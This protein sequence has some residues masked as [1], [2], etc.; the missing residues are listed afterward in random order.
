MPLRE[1]III[2]VVMLGLSAFFSGAETALVSISNHRVRHMAQKGGRISKLLLRLKEDPQRMLTTILIGNNLVNIGAAAFATSIAIGI[3]G[4]TGVGIATGVMTLLILIFGEITPKSLATQFN[5]GYSKLAALPIW[6]LSVILYPFIK[7]FDWFFRIV[8]KIFGGKPEKQS[9]SED[10][11]KSMVSISE[12]EGEIKE[13]EK[14]MVNKIFEFDDINADEIMTPK[15]D[16]FLLD[17]KIKVKKALKEALL[18]P[19]SRIPVYEDN[20][21]NIV[22]IVHLRDLIEASSKKKNDTTV[23]KIMKKPYFVPETK[24]IDSLLKQFQKKKEHMAII[25]DEHGIITGLVT[26]ED[27]LE[28]IVGE[29]MDET[30]KRDPNIQD[31]KKKN[32]WIVKGKTDIDEANDALG[33]NIPDSEEY[34][35]VGGF[36]LTKVGRIPK[37]GEK[38][39]HKK[40]TII[41][42][43]IEEHRIIKVK[44]IGK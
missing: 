30:D 14:E 38:I 41:I 39:K 1:Q 2:L 32:Q 31:G 24:K 23:E 42:E 16:M 6:Y 43:E 9:L 33:L 35:T 44:V 25:V 18:K 20:S 13:M 15:T 4:D 27:I 34:D 40:F 28:E 11:L 19:H 7:I 37:K 10:Y 3:F 12:E 36:I 26:L 21:E 17:S 29:I 22:G 5:E 8:L